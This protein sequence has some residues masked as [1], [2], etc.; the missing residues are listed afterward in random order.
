MIG[1]RVDCPRLALFEMLQAGIDD[2][3][4]AAKLG[5]PSVA[6]IVEAIVDVRAQIGDPLICIILP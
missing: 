5:S 4:Y 6:H 2:F 3:L 1:D